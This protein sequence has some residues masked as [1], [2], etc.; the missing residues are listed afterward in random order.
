MTKITKIHTKK[1]CVLGSANGPNN[2]ND[3]TNI[4]TIANSQMANI[5][6][7]IPF[8]NLANRSRS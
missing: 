1:S 7:S 5:N 6:N 3:N 4:A 2:N 8:G